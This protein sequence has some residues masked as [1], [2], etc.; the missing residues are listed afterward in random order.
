MKHFDKHFKKYYE[1]FERYFS[2]RDSD[3]SSTI[4]GS[5]K[6]IIEECKNNKYC[7]YDLWNKWTD[8]SSKISFKSN[9]NYGDG[10]EKLG[11][12]YGIIPMGQNSSYDLDMPFNQ[13]WECKKLDKDG[14]F[15]LGVEISSE[16]TIILSNIL[17]IFN[18]IKNIYTY[19]QDGSNIKNSLKKIITKLN[20]T[21]KKCKT[22]LINGLK[23]HEVSESN[24][25]KA[26]DMIENIKKITSLDNDKI[27]LYSSYDGKKYN[28]NL[29]DAYN[30][31]HL[32]NINIKNIIST[33]GDIETYN[34]LC[35][36][37]SI[38]NNIKMFNNCT[39]LEKL[40]EIIR[41]VFKNKFLVFVDEI[42]GYKP[43]TK[44]HYII[45]YRITHGKPRCKYIM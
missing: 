43:I 41:N 24:L 37:N 18:N 17:Y 39:L 45:C 35:I 33:I 21:T 13:R 29:L 15:R 2:D 7:K 20:E 30:K 16:Y 10:E 36:I 6:S 5:D 22:S 19:L 25:K 31:L 28:Y 14:S 23:K 26:N 11:S 42:K 9:N 3:S 1:D 12:E 4:Q 27:E 38:K 32:E 8:K 40:N 44:L 34:Q